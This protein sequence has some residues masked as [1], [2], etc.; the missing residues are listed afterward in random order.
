MITK[1]TYKLQGNG[2]DSW[3]VDIHD[4]QTVEES[5]IENRISREIVFKD[6][7]INSD[8]NMS[9]LDF[10]KLTIVQIRQLKNILGIN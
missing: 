4:C 7:N 2:Q 5:T 3:H 1:Y 9:N 10:T 6:P 8:T